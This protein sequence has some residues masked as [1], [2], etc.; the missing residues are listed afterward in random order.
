MRGA[1]KNDRITQYQ[2][3]RRINEILEDTVSALDRL[4][5]NCC[6]A[7]AGRSVLL[8]L[9]F[10]YSKSLFQVYNC[11]SYPQKECNAPFPDYPVVRRMSSFQYVF[12]HFHR[13]SPRALERLFLI[14]NHHLFPFFLD[15][16]HKS[17]I[18]SILQLGVNY[19]ENLN[20]GTSSETIYSTA[21][22]TIASLAN[23]HCVV[24]FTNSC[25]ALTLV[26]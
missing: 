19:S 9:L 22:Y 21:I 7:I 4:S 6:Y 16:C 20:I 15:L 18:L 10:Y 12:P 26:Q 3:L 1:S 17:I 5:I 25:C 24:A 23:L 11:L 13:L 14:V 8:P 2:E